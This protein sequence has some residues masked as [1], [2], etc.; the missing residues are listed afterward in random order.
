MNIPKLFEHFTQTSQKHAAL[1]PE[2]PEHR[3]LLTSALVGN[4]PPDI[5]KQIQNGVVGWPE[6][7]Y[8]IKCNNGGSNTIL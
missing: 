8:I 5:K 4:S 2:A 1:D 6:H 3:N 7:D